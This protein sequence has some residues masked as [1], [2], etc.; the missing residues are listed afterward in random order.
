[1]PAA[2]SIDSFTYRSWLIGTVSTFVG[3]MVAALTATG[4]TV[5]AQGDPTRGVIEVIVALTGRWLLGVGTD[6]W[7]GFTARVMR[8]RGRRTIV[9]H[10]DRPLPEGDR[11]RRD[12][13]LAI[14]HAAGAPALDVVG[15]SARTAILGVAV[16][17][18]MAGWLSAGIV[19]ALLLMAVPLYRRAGRRGA[20]LT[21]EYNDRRRTLER[22]QLEL[23]YHAPELRGLGA[24]AYGADEI[25][26]I[27]DAEH[28]VAIRAIRVA[29]ESSLVT[30][31][32]S[33]VSVGLVAMVVGFKLLRGEIGLDH[34]LVAVLVTSELFGA[35]RRFGVEFH[36]RE[37]AAPSLDTLRIAPRP[38]PTRD[39]PL[40]V[41]R[42]LVTGVGSGAVSLD[43]DAG[44]RLLITGPSGAGKTTLVQTLVGWRA[45]VSGRV[46]R[47]TG[48]IAVVSSDTALFAGTLWENLT[49][50][51]RVDRGLVRARLE[52]LGLTGPRF[53]DLDAPLL[54]DGEGLS[55]GERVRLAIARA[56]LAEPSLL[57]LDDIAGVLDEVNRGRVADVV[58]AVEGLAVIEATVDAPLVVTSGPR[59]ELG[60]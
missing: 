51:H 27:S 50:G 20:A 23:L 36:R 33:G 5:I 19:M 18:W 11:S 9:D 24:V 60:R 43:V 21:A 34:A 40:V 35:V 56:T 14:D 46:V 10:L 32:L 31:F 41:A 8:E 12:L 2:A 39:G 48:V 52:Q 44:G 26:A 16:V 17:W 38:T 58:A 25:A 7:A 59:I 6:G 1:M 49:L 4:I 22:R 28:G 53:D 57:V 45:P 37:D 47:R 54:A 30:E 3:F 29:L 13:A 55:T 15:A 42:D